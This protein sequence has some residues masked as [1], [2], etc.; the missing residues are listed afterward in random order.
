MAVNK[1]FVIKN[2]IQVNENLLYGDPDQTRVSIGTYVPLHTLHV[3]G[4][5]GATHA[6]V[7]GISTFDRNVYVG[8]GFEVVGVTSLSSAGGMTT[9]G[10]SLRIGRGLFVQDGATIT[11]VTTINNNADFNR[12][13]DVF[14]QTTTKDLLVTGVGTITGIGS[15]GSN[16][17]IAGDLTVNGILLNGGSSIGTDVST[18]NL[19]VSGLSTFAGLSTF[20]SGIFV[21]GVGT[22]AND[23]DINASVDIDGHTELDNLNVSGVSTFVGLSTFQNGIYVT[24]VST[25]VNDLDINANVDIFGTIELDRL[26][27][28]GM[29]TLAAVDINAGEVGVSTI[30]SQFLNVTGVSTLA[31]V[32]IN[33]GEVGVQTV[34]TV[35]LNVSAASTFGGEVDINNQVQVSGATTFASNVTV[36]GVSDL[37]TTTIGGYLD[38]NNSMDVAGIST[39]Q[40]VVNFEEGAIVVGVSTFSDNLDI[41]ASVDIDGHTELDNL[42]VSG[43]STFVGMSTFQDG[44]YVTGVA[45]FAQGVDIDG[46]ID[47]DGHLEVD[48]LRASGVSTFVGM[49]TFQNGI[50]VTG[51]STFANNLDINASVD[52]SNDLSV[53]GNAGIGSL[54][55]SGISTFTGNIDVNGDVDVD[56][57]LEVDHINVSGASTIGGRVDI[58]NSVD[59]SNDLLVTGVSTFSSNLDINANVDI[60]GDVNITGITTV[61]DLVVTGVTTYQDAIVGG[62]ATFTSIGIKTATVG[63]HELKV[64]GD[65]ELVGELN[66]TGLTTFSSNIQGTNAVFSGNVT[67]TQFV[68]FG[69]FIDGIVAI[70]TR[71]YEVGSGINTAPGDLW[72]NAETGIGYVYYHDPSGDEFWV[73]FSGQSGGPTSGS[74]N[75]LV[76]DTSPQLGGN[77]DLNGK[78]ITGTGNINITGNVNF[79]GSISGAGITASQVT[80]DVNPGTATSHQILVSAGATLDGDYAVFADT[81]F[82][83]T[84]S[85]DTLNTVDV[86]SRNI[87]VGIITATTLH[88]DGS[89]ITGLATT[90]S[91]NARFLNAG[92]TTISEL[93]TTGVSTFMGPVG[94]GTFDEEIIDTNNE[95]TLT[96][97]GKLRVVGTNP[98]QPDSLTVISFGTP[99]YN[100]TYVRNSNVRGQTD[101]AT[102]AFNV[103]GSLYPWST[104]YYDTGGGNYYVI[105]RDDTIWKIFT[106]SVDPTTFVDGTSLLM[107]SVGALASASITKDG[108]ES[109][110]VAD[111]NVTYSGSTPVGIGTTISL[112]GSTGI[113][114][115]TT[116]YGDGS[117]LTGI[118]A[119]DNTS[120]NTLVVTGVSTLGIITSN[121]SYIVGVS[122]IDVASNV[123]HKGLD[124]LTNQGNINLGVRSDY[125]RLAFTGA[126]STAV[127][128]E[129]YSTPTAIIIDRPGSGG[130]AGIKMGG[131]YNLFA[132][133]NSY[134][135]LNYAGETRLQTE[136]GGVVITGIATATNVSVASSVTAVS[137]Y[138]DGANLTG[139][140]NTGDINAD[141]ITVVGVVTAA[142]F[143]GDGSGLSNLTGIGTGVFIQD[144]DADVGAA[145]TINFGK[146]ISVSPIEAGI[147]TITGIGTENVTS[148]TLVAG[149]ATITTLKVG[150]AITASNGIVTAT[151]FVGDGSNLTGIAITANVST[152]TLVVSGVSTLG[153]VT[154]TSFYGN[155]RFLTGI[156]TQTVNAQF[157]NG[158]ITTARQLNVQGLQV[159]DYST[160]TLSN[161]SPSSFN[162]EYTRQATGFTLD[163]NNVSS[164]NALFHADS[165]YYYYSKVGAAST[166]IIFSNE[167]NSGNGQWIAF[168]KN[169]SDF[170][171]GNI[172][173][174]DAL[175]ATDALVGL[176]LTSIQYDNSRESI[177]GSSTV[178]YNSSYNTG[179]STL[180]IATAN[181]LYVTGVSTFN[182]NVTLP[183]GQH[184]ILGDGLDDSGKFKIY[185]GANEPFEIYGSAKEAYIRNTGS[186]ANGISIAAN[187]SVT[188]SGGGSGN[189]SV[190]ARADGSARLLYAVSPKLDTTSTGV[191]ITG[192]ATANNVSASSS[193]TAVTY[194]G[195]GSNL[196]GIAVTANV[197]TNTLVVSGV[198]TLGVVTATSFYGNGRFLTGISTQTV[199]AQFLN[200]GITTARQLNV[201]GLQVFDY[202][203]VTLSNLSPSSFNGEYTRQATGFTLDTNNVS[204]GNALF[205]ADSNYYYYSKVGA[206]STAIIF[207][208]EDNSGNGQWIAFYKNGSDFT[209]GNI[210]NN[211]ALGATDALVGLALTSI[212]YDNSR[213]SIPG[214]STVVYNSSYNTGISTLGIATA[215]QLYVTGVSTFNGNVTLPNGQ[216]LILGDG[217]DDS[218]KFKIYNGANEP[219]EIYGSAKEAYIR[220][221][222]SNAN[223]ISIAANTSVTLSGGGSGNFSVHARADGSARLLYAVSPK[224][225]TTST[226]VVITGIATANNVS[227]SSSVTAVTYYGDGSNLTGIAVTANVSTNTLVVSGVST[228]GVVTS[229]TYYG[230]GSQLVDGR[231]TLG[232]NG[233]SDY[234]FTGIGF[235]QTTADPVLFL[236]RGR[237]Y[238]FVNNM[239]AHPFRIQSTSNGSTGTAFIDGITNNDVSNGVLTFEVPFNAPNTL[240]YQCTAHTGMGGTIT[241]YP[242]V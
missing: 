69:S 152:N 198:S 203:T 5:I 119:T 170:T 151:S 168:Y 116:Y 164:G 76:R 214:S 120:T 79:T 131:E 39:F 75:D 44:I 8:G 192:I 153:V 208:N 135:R 36:N 33:A 177:P 169:G 140:A 19:T 95:F 199:N 53:T 235:T 241:I 4:G 106:T 189:F 49:S 150:T 196:T 184:L 159:F 218:G 20:Q 207:S 103:D 230:D 60:S 204:S 2:G 144:D 190:H 84:P 166:A 220:N 193:V 94:I 115:A 211:D 102:N 96:T 72:W 142:T 143:I 37:F 118:A 61:H 181:Q 10:G 92:I 206:A 90:E 14:V 48:N 113:I 21:S 1:N 101:E 107:T 99:A 130:F 121:S 233:S 68:G 147:T 40:K 232:A 209:E 167:D 197:S 227:A 70:G 43:V 195:D 66:V 205:H 126:G 86:V 222:G 137:F 77:L 9:T 134:T 174:N 185:N 188:L 176:A 27:V 91:I 201:Q 34:N 183:N 13:L 111:P 187:T 138:G 32:D 225:D 59:I 55:V 73:D 104:Y 109:P 221:T 23:L 47:I 58:N 217:L 171:E 25:F 231:W 186:N 212:Q 124:I 234:T 16:V 54:I 80:V 31:Y 127:V 67:A 125:N 202:S 236:A 45:T 122:T 149:I 240:Y 155:G 112:D 108:F 110:D 238:Q 237:K 93:R 26:N 97:K 35:S 6:Y 74:I 64:I 145:T 180:G 11:G 18:R 219:F 178:V 182:G 38:I 52:I 239:G 226:G 136:S 57:L 223:G 83:Y 50:Y 28:S 46:D 157:L 65:T 17:D 179:I 7:T 98:Y 100:Q 30:T 3:I 139:I 228:V 215:N 12:N 15:F 78:D 141:R 24:G 191:V 51:V 242:T 129:I 63:D 41:N 224:L 175:G 148:D 123:F 56:G 160:V 158:G 173:N 162:G 22:F 213:E 71:P 210:S 82:Y 133:G 229:G 81:D 156:S 88:G 105:G 117:N 87:T 132:A 165:N 114:S 29:S 194:Y 85:T 161:L 216:H 172:S 163:T 89:N 200:G 42:N 154:A 146:Y 128:S 62:A